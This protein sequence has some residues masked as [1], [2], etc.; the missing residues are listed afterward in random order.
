MQSAP[1]LA[2]QLN[3]PSS[4][5]EGMAHVAARRTP[6]HCRIRDRLLH[7]SLQQAVEAAGAESVVARNASEA[8]Q[9]CDQLQFTAALLNVEHRT[10]ED[11]LSARGLP[12]LLYSRASM[13]RA[14]IA[15]LQRLLEVGR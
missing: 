2:Q 15:S 5:R 8:E 14:I 7:L 10:I 13:P 4:R 9:H 1:I 6:T 3:A 11:D 12:V